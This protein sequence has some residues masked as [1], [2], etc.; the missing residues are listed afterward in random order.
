MASSVYSYYLANY[1]SKEV[2]RY[3]THKKG[4]LRSVY[5]A[6][7]KLN[8]ESPL[9]KI[10]FSEDTCKYAIDIKE[11]A[12]SIKNI[13]N[14]LSEDSVSGHLLGFGKKVAMSSNED[15]VIATYIGDGSE[16]VSVSNLNIEVQSLATTQINIGNFLT[17]WELNIEP[18]FYSFDIAISDLSYEFQFKIDKND[19]NRSLQEKLGNIV[20]KSGI[21]LTCSVIE[22]G[23]GHTSL[24]IESKDTGL[25]GQR[26]K[27]FSVSDDNTSIQSG[28]VEYL[29]INSINQ[30]PQNAVFLLNGA[31]QSSN[32][33]TF[34]VNKTFE[35]TL[36]KPAIDE[37]VHIRFK[38]DIDSI[39]D[40]VYELVEGYN[41][42]ISLGYRYAN[43]H[44]R[45]NKLISDFSTIAWAYKNQL[46]S[47]GLSLMKDQT[48]DVDEG[49]LIQSLKEDDAAKTFEGIGAFK[50]DLL[51]KSNQMFL[52]PMEYVDKVVVAYKNPRKSLL[53][54]YITSI[55]SGLMFNRWY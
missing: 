3:D 46:E 27:T 14:S 24:K 11:G 12:R 2:S 18:G 19:T 31:T 38:E 9:Y 40:N 25:L 13:L 20:T 15:I 37:E 50:N 4:E 32:S 26:K 39:V 16:K 1:V 5:N 17:P 7:L 44:E 36:L 41:S 48:I 43:R 10:D 33:N 34:T 45:S 28:T 47:T 29:G 52:D 51:K 54:P 53:T 35:L 8:K 23:F 55:Y 22:D 30:Y 21:G 42:I 6:I 49:L